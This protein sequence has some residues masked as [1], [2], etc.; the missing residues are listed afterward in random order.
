MGSTLRI[1]SGTFAGVSGTRMVPAVFT[2]TITVASAPCGPMVPHVAPCSCGGGRA[3]GAVAV[4]ASGSKLSWA[5]TS[6]S[7]NVA[8]NSRKIIAKSARCIVGIPLESAA[9]EAGKMPALPG[10]EAGNACAPRAQTGR[11]QA[12][13]CTRL[14]EEVG[15][16]CRSDEPVEYAGS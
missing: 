6:V 14:T 2:P 1:R 7:A 16:A 10:P 15:V 9:I 4:A 13:P 5:F 3:A 8:E 12:P 11:G